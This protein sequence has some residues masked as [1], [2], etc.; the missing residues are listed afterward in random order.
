LSE[1]VPPAQRGSRKF[2]LG[3]PQETTA[4]V[5]VVVPVP[6]SGPGV[7]VVVVVLDEPEQSTEPPD[8]SRKIVV[9]SQPAK[10]T[11]AAVSTAILCQPSSITFFARRISLLIPF[12]Y[13]RKQAVPAPCAICNQ[14]ARLNLETVVTGNRRSKMQY[15]SYC[16]WR[17]WHSSRR[18]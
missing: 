10:M 12:T 4:G 7:V 2:T 13:K 1:I 16:M 6:G 18:S 15:L 14:I 8:V 3:S 11:P 5:V 9:T 17:E